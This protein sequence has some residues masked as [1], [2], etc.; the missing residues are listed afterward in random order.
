MKVSAE[1]FERG[2]FL[3]VPGAHSHTHLDTSGK[4]PQAHAIGLRRK[5]DRLRPGRV[6]SEASAKLAAP[7]LDGM[8]SPPPRELTAVQRSA[9]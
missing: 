1:A 4:A 7:F 5:V 3:P 9:D 8:Q 6:D 2:A